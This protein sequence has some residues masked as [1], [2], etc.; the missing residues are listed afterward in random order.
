MRA[1]P[2]VFGKRFP[3]L[4]TALRTTPGVDGTFGATS[5]PLSLL[6]ERCSWSVPS[7]RLS[8]RLLGSRDQPVYPLAD[9][10]LLNGGGD[11]FLG[12][13]R[14]P[15]PFALLDLL[16]V[17]PLRIR[18]RWK[19]VIKLAAAGEKLFDQSAAGLGLA[20]E[21]YGVWTFM[22]LSLCTCGVV[23][24]ASSMSSGSIKS[25]SSDSLLPESEASIFTLPTE[26]DTVDRSLFM[27][28]HPE[29]G[30][31]LGESSIIELME[32]LREGMTTPF[33]MMI[34]EESGEDCSA[35]VE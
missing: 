18:E 19:L 22:L 5:S 28:G 17:L 34:G 27:V 4:V 8:L 1:N 33:C 12:L 2:F 35:R 14:A 21:A 10:M 32:A 13:G 6:E 20:C 9:S 11:V 26:L 29:L 16:L 15:C 25:S 7:A 23:K 30:P 3:R 31:R 24:M